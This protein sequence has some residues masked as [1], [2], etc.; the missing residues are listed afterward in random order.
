[1]AQALQAAN[2]AFGQTSAQTEM[3]LHASSSVRHTWL[4]SDWAEV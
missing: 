3:A 4:S 1:M 2:Q